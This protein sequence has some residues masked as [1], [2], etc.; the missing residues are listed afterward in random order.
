M[1]VSGTFSHLVLNII[2]QI[3]VIILKRILRVNDRVIKVENRT[4][5]YRVPL[6]VFSIN[7]L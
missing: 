4:K 7:L 1:V 6:S 5:R 3:N 2:L